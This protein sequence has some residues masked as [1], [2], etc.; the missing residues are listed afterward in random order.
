MASWS[1]WFI[2]GHEIEKLGGGWFEM[3]GM[4]TF[5]SLVLH[6]LFCNGRS[7]L[8][9]INIELIPWEKIVVEDVNRFGPAPTSC[10]V[11]SRSCHFVDSCTMCNPAAAAAIPSGLF[12]FLTR[13]RAFSLAR[14]PRANSICSLRLSFLQYFPP[15]GPSSRRFTP[16][17]PIAA[18]VAVILSFK[19]GWAH[20]KSLSV[21]VSRAN[22][23]LA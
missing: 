22:W 11:K 13:A 20:L 6:Y 8:I 5:S 1:R 14:V 18:V 19:P 10:P 12:L 7:T 23:R 2:E 17:S 4:P 16:M 9:G 3:R 21:R 15:S